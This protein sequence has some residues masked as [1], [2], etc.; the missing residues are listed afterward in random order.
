MELI[1]TTTQRGRELLVF[2]NQVCHTV[3]YNQDFQIFYTGQ[4]NYVYD[5]KAEKVIEMTVEGWT[6]MV[7]KLEVLLSSISELT[8]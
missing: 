4:G 8:T 5:K 2:G 1:W 6:R 3:F 7:Q